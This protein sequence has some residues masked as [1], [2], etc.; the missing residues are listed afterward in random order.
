MS[1]YEPLGPADVGHR[2]SVRRTVGERDGRPLLSD[3]LGHLEEVSDTVLA[4]RRKDGTLVTV[5]RTDVTA[6][7]RVG[8]E[9]AVRA[10]RTAADWS[11]LEL[12]Q[13]AWTGWPG[14]EQEHLGDWVLRAAGGFTGRANSALPLGDPGLPLDGAIAHVID[15]YVARGLRPRFQVPTPYA[16]PVDDRL[17]A[18][19]WE[20]FDPV[21]VMAADVERVLTGTPPKLDLPAVVVAEQPDAG[22]LGAYHYRGGG[23]PDRAWSVITAGVGAAFASVR[24]EA[25]A[26][27]AIARVAVNAGWAGITAVEVDASVR[28]RGLGTHVMREAV[29]W[30]GRQGARHAYL[31]VASDNQPALGLYGRMGFVTHHHYHYRLAPQ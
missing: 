9:S 7:R 4:V 11:D 31:Q 24:D 17:A 2:V 15:F 30:A 10:T 28:R 8:G 21:H 19:G 23:L 29:A 6:S 3:V 18:L 14:L 25:D 16:R 12:E 5:A 22:W 20:V 27:L 1:S 26:V 13:I